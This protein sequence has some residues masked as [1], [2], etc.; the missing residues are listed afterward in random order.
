MGAE[1]TGRMQTPTDVRSVISINPRKIRGNWRAG[2]ALDFHTVSS[3]LL[4]D[5]GYDTERTQIGEWV[6]QVKYRS[7]QSKIRPLAE[8]AAKFV[9]EEFAVDGHLVLPYLAA[10]IPVPPSDLTRDFQLVTEIAKEMGQMLNLR[11][12]TDYLQ[13]E[14][15]TDLLKNLPDVERKREELRGA[16][17]IQSPVLQ[18]KVVLLI[19]DIFDSGTTLRTATEILYRQGG[20]R[21]VLVLTFTKTREKR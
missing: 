8:R 10:V 13:K 18:K 16:F 12:Y 9:K 6:F 7:D 19:D 21:Y 1:A 4:P 14:K 11:V 2:Y 15:Q 20:V 3:R 5:E 17:V